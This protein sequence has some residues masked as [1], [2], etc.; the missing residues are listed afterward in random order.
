MSDKL[1][2]EAEEY[3]TDYLKKSRHVEPEIHQEVKAAAILIFKAGHASR[4]LEV[5][6]LKE[7]LWAAE[8]RLKGMT[9]GL[10]ILKRGES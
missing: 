1:N 9:E 6:A 8:G 3:A 2:Q 10:E 7:K 5:A 4:D